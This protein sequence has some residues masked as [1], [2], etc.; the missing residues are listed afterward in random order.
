VLVSHKRV[1]FLFNID[2]F[3]TVPKRLTLGRFPDLTLAQAREKVPELRQLLKE[4]KDP[5]V[6]LKR[7]AAPTGATLDDCVHEFLERH[8]AR[9][10]FH[11]FIKTLICHNSIGYKFYC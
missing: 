9:H 7:L 4:G 11:L 5:S 10:N 1:Q 6:E 2:I 3:Q 8:I